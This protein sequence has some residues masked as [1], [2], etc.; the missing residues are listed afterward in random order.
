MKY[1]L[2]DYSKEQRQLRKEHILQVASEVAILQGSAVFGHLYKGGRM[3]HEL[4][5]KHGYGDCPPVEYKFIMVSRKKVK[6]YIAK[7]IQWDSGDGWTTDF[8]FGLLQCGTISYHGY[9]TTFSWWGNPKLTEILKKSP[10]AGEFC[11]NAENYS[12]PPRQRKKWKSVA[13][14]HMSHNPFSMEYIAGVF[15]SGKLIEHDGEMCAKYSRISCAV[16]R[17]YGVPIKE[18]GRISPV[19]PALFVSYMPECCSS[20]WLDIKKCKD[21]HILPP[22]LWYMYIN[23]HFASGAIP[24]LKARRTVFYNLKCE[25]G[26]KHAM[27][28]YRMKLGIRMLDARIGECIREWYSKSPV[29]HRIKPRDYNFNPKDQTGKQTRRK[30][31]TR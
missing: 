2:I 10:F 25:N 1:F 24:Y 8:L 4:W 12:S 11:K 22:V 23:M 5:R 9:N 15:A 28:E 3:F 17:D 14:L 27:E 30:R 18:D 19:W 21:E 29:K 13:A 7:N 6:Q 26:A 20:M 16:L 31:K